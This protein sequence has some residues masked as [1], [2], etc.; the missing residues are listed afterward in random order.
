M[1]LMIVLGVGL[2]ALGACCVGAGK[3][4][5][6][7]QLPAETRAQFDQMAAQ[8]NVSVAAVFQVMI[9]A[10][11]LCVVP[12]LALLVLSIFVY[13]R[14]LA[15]TIV[16]LVVAALMLLGLGVMILAS[17]AGADANA[18]VGVAM[19]LIPLALTIW[20]VVLLGQSIKA[21]GLHR[22]ELR[23]QQWQMGQSKEKKTRYEQGEGN[24][25]GSR[26]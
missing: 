7:A 17:A 19:M 21:A 9:V 22:D 11:V 8:N 20:L 16:A 14:S 12:A 18:I 6:L 15:G 24:E 25:S 4:M 26:D 13:R 3:F 23:R 5:S 1:I 10:G 2:L